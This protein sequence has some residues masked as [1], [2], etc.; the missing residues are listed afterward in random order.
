MMIFKDLEINKTI[1]RGSRKMGPALFGDPVVSPLKPTP[2][3]MYN[4]WGLKA[5]K[6][7]VNGRFSSTGIF[8]QLNGIIQDV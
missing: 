8:Y 6:V 7:A 5:L 4:R 2:R 1:I 3:A